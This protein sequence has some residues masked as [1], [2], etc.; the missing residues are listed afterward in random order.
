MKQWTGAEYKDMV[1]VWFPVC[2]LL[3]KGHPDHFK[4]IKSVTHLILIASY[5]SHTETTLKYLQNA[6]SAIST[7]IHLFLPYHK[8]HSMSKIPRIHS[9]LRYIECSR[10]MG[11]A[12]NSGPAVSEATHTNLIKDGDQFSYKVDYIPQMLRWEMHLIHLKLSVFYLVLAT[13][14][15]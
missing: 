3:L 9:L 11:F 12:D 15:N 10:E 2:A 5:H 8:S 14:P 13:S 4:F 7:N 1:K 6:V